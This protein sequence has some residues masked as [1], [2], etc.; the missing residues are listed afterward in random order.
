MKEKE[1]SKNNSPQFSEN[2]LI[3]VDESISPQQITHL[4]MMLLW[5]NHCKWKVSLS[6]MER[7]N[8]RKCY[9]DWKVAVTLIKHQIKEYFNA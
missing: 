1:K 3:L 8:S 6:R 7:H 2:E 9:E 4:S 5:V